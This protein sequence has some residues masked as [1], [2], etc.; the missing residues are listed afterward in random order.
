PFPAPAQLLLLK[1]ALCEGDEAIR[2]WQ[3]W[4]KVFDLKDPLDPGSYRTLPLLYRNLSLLLPEEP[5]LP[6]LKAAYRQSWYRNQQLLHRGLPAIRLLETEGIRCM[7]LKGAALGAL[8]YRDPGIRYMA[9]LDVMVKPERAR[10]AIGLL[11]KAGWM[12]DDAGGMEYN[13]RYGRALGFR[14]AE[15]WE[16]DL[17]W[18]A[19]FEGLRND[20]ED[21][22][23]NARPMKLHDTEVSALESGVML[24]HVIA[25]GMRWNPDPPIRWIPDSIQLIRSME[26]DDWERALSLARAYRLQ[27][28]LQHAL[29]YL[30]EHFSISIPQN[31]LR[32]LQE[33]PAGF[34]ERFLFRE[35]LRRDA[36]RLPEAF[37]PRFR[38]LFGVYVR[39]SGKTGLLANIIGFPAFLAYRTRGKSRTRMLAHYLGRA[40]GRKTVSPN[41]PKP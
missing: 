4:Q 30:E 12:P 38:Y 5:L 8:W 15:G 7:L 19:F 36:E 21:L 33:T 13:L 3:A 26:E 27:L 23:L 35:H 16:L 9:D 14:D 39:Q 24:V 2:S 11:Q 6:K 34:A 29:Q 41:L 10:E 17:H 1:A 22:W 37:F 32:E 31:I 28:V 20:T 25:H 18:H 40:L